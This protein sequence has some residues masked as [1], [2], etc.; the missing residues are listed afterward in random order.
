MQIR[1]IRNIERRLTTSVRGLFSGGV[2]GLLLFTSQLAGLGCG[3]RTMLGSLPTVGLSAAALEHPS[4]T[5]AA[6]GR[7][8]SSWRR[9]AAGGGSILAPAAWR[10]VVHPLAGYP[11]GRG[12]RR[13]QW[14]KRQRC[15]PTVARKLSAL[16]L[17]FDAVGRSPEGMERRPWGIRAGH[18]R[19]ATD[20]LGNTGSA[21]T[22]RT[23]GPG[24]V[25]QVT[26]SSA[27]RELV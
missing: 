2:L 16:L 13:C 20:D 7:R 3:G 10:L 27:R 18:P 19:R 22:R 26:S 17:R 21:G 4:R 12:F 9:I 11:W 24:Q 23:P 6:L 14:F 25:C 8:C 5:R 1:K 15:A